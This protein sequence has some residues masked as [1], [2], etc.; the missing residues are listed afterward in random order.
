VPLPYYSQATYPDGGF[1]ASVADLSKYLVELIRGHQGRG[2]VLRPASYSEL[3]R[4]AL[5]AIQFEKCNERN[6]YSESYN[7]G[8]L[9][10]FG[11]TNFWAYRREP[12]RGRAPVFRP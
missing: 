1:C 4:P 12:R 10:G 3:F 7:V 11:Y 6:P 8:V 5:S 2:T 9:M